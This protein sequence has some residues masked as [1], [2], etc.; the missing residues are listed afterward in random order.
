MPK[1]L[2]H[3]S[4]KNW[5]FLDGKSGLSKKIKVK[6]GLKKQE[7]WVD[8][9]VLFQGGLLFLRGQIFRP[10]ISNFLVKNALNF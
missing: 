8:G 2:K 1:N 6:M 4:P 9:I 5:K 3:F 10:G 7:A